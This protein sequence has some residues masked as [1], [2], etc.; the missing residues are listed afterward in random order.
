MEYTEANPL[1]RSKAISE[2]QAD[3]EL[4]LYLTEVGVFTQED[5]NTPVETH[6]V[7]IASE[8]TSYVEHIAID[9]CQNA[10]ELHER[11]FFDQINDIEKSELSEWD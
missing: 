10:I 7:L 4:N 1:N 11:D 6:Y 2:A 9:L 5:T 3:S 8:D